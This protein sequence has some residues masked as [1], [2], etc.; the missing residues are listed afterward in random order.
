MRPH[1]TSRS[2]DG[3]V[4]GAT[5]IGSRRCL[6]ARLAETEQQPSPESRGLQTSQKLQW[7]PN[8]DVFSYRQSAHGAYHQE[9]TVE[10]TI[11]RIP[12]IVHVHFFPL[13]GE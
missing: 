10:V 13:R 3:F 11:A 1:V 12:S 8:L 7:Y 2:G 9:V 6:Q 5:V 4:K